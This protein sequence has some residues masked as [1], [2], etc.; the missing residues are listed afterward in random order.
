MIISI[1][2]PGVRDNILQHGIKA[3]EAT[4]YFWISLTKTIQEI[5][6][7]VPNC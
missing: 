2:G 7:S 6:K 1:N 3:T 5:D 4:R